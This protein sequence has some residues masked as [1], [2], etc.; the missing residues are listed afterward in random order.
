MKKEI[1]IALL[2]LAAIAIAF[3]GINFLK[4]KNIFL[5]QQNYYAVYPRV[6][7]LTATNPIWVNGLK[8]GQVARID[9]VPGTNDK[10][11]V[12]LR[13]TNPSV[14]LTQNTV[15]KII[16]ADILGSKGVDLLIKP[17]IE[18][19]PGDTLVSDLEE[20]IMDVVS[21]QL[22]PLQAK[23]ENLIT[24]VDS[25]LIVVRTV[26]NESSLDQLGQSFYSIR[27]TFESL[28]ASAKS[29]E[30][31]LAEEK[32]NIARA[33][34]NVA[35]TTDVLQKNAEGLD[36]SIKNV[37][38]ITGDL[39]EAELKETLL[40]AQETVANLETILADIKNGKGSLGQLTQTD[41]LHNR[42]VAAVAEL[43]YLL[44]DIRRNPGRYV[45]FNLIG[46]KQRGVS[47]TQPEEQKL[48]EMLNE[49]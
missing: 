10:L 22:A 47:L 17:G 12:T 29:V 38:K 46:R 11:L 7:G 16:S 44:E 43:E 24:S 23:A 26:L 27:G 3:I 4:G 28:L 14:H 8:V 48:M 41:S 21:E 35:V 2:V 40:K 34:E 49:E 45:S 30:E 18:A 15:A 20:G 31:L 25:V 42:A 5:P 1:K 36:A 6:D 39:A 9:F 13:V 19:E 33:V 32:S 37:E